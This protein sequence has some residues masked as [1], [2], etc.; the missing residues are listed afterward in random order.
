MA[1]SAWQVEVARLVAKRI[2]AKEEGDFKAAAW[3][4]IALQQHCAT[5]PPGVEVPDLEQ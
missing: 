5:A 4:K 2:E 1:A 3:L